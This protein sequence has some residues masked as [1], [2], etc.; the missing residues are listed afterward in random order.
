M[1]QIDVQEENLAVNFDVQFWGVRS[2]I[3]APGKD[4]IRYG[5]NTSC[6][7]MRIG[8]QR[9][10]FDGGTGLR[11]LGNSLL[12]QMPLE[13]HMFFTHCHWDRIQGF[14]FFVPAFIGINHLHIYG[15]SASN[16][17]TFKQRLHEQ[18]LG[19]NFPVPM[20]VMKSKMEFYDMA[21]EK[22]YSLGEVKV[23][24]KFLD[25]G[26]RSLGYRVN[27]QGKSVVYATGCQYVTACPNETLLALTRGADLLIVDAPAPGGNCSN[28]ARA[29]GID[30]AWR[31]LSLTVTK[32]A[33]VKRVVLSLYNPDDDDDLLDEVEKKLNSALPSVRLAREGMVV[34]VV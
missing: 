16:G 23:E 5:G 2:Q 32:E 13:V 15:A 28:G 19:P 17:A 26:H 31:Q 7:E 25:P 33:L 18:M 1:T 11:Q 29:K 10:I 14:P 20:Q 4:T 30:G 24:A 27:Y 3:A 12:G 9:L 22:T 8:G 6:V 21:T 34:S